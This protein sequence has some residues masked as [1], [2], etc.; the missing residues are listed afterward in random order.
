MLLASPL[1]E[2][3]VSASAVQ[4]RMHILPRQGRVMVKKGELLDSK[5]QKPLQ[6]RHTALLSLDGGGLRGILTGGYL[7]QCEQ[8]GTLLSWL[9]PMT[10]YPEQVSV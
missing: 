7:N 1:L 4:S 10:E 3:M 8:T 5:T 6:L 2:L 9:I